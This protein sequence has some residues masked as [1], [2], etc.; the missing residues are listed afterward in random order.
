MAIDSYLDMRS[1]YGEKLNDNSPLIR[2]EFN[3]RDLKQ[4]SCDMTRVYKF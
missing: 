4:H 3:I 2:E 1:R